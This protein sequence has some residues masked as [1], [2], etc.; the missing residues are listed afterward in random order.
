MITG[1]SMKGTQTEKSKE[2]HSTETQ[3][4]KVISPSQDDS[5]IEGNSQA[6]KTQAINYQGTSK[7][8]STHLKLLN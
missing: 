2:E 1:L 6:G 5:D 4:D 3:Y 8:L 7:P